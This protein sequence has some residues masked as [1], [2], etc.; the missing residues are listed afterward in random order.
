MNSG[1][2]I[3]RKHSEYFS[4]VGVAV[5]FVMFMSAFAGEAAA[6]EHVTSL[7]KADERVFFSCPLRNT[8][9]TVSICA[10]APKDGPVQR[11]T[12]RYGA[13]R[14]ELQFEANSQNQNRFSA[15][16]GPASPNASVRQVWFERKGVRYIVSSC[17]GG[18][19]PHR[20]GL[21]VRR[22]KRV[23]TSRACAMDS[24]Q[25]VSQPW[26]LSEVLKFGSDID[27]S[28]SKTDLIKLED[29]D[30]NIGVLY[31]TKRVD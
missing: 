1:A 14:A 4:R 28:Q 5:V 23:L 26:F 15:T 8:K 9:K 25:H 21:I 13:G 17:I 20:G 3:S 31:P 11:L 24:A 22:G 12:Y 10:A 2:R 6:E 30:N 7:C 19:C 27:G 16:V 18:D 29:V